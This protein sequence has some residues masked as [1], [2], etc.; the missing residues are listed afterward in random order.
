MTIYLY[1]APRKNP[2]WVDTDSMS[3][4]QKMNKGISCFTYKK[5]SLFEEALDA[6]DMHYGQKPIELHN[7]S[8]SLQLI[9]N[10]K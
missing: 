8:A 7:Y 6:L 1:T 3:V 5:L 2:I 4:I 10:T 9:I